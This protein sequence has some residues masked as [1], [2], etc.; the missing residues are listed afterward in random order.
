MEII[1]YVKERKALL[2]SEI[3]LRKANPVL[4][5]V[6]VNDDYASDKYI[7][8]KLNDALEVGIEARHIKLSVA[9]SEEE[10]LSL[11]DKLNVQKD[12]HGIIVQ[13]PLPRHISEEKVKARISVKKDVDGF[14]PLSTFKACTPLGIINYLKAEKVVFSGK[15]ALVIGRSNIVG[16][17]MA[18]LLLNE[19][20]TVTIVH[21]KTTKEDL[22]LYLSRADIIVVAV[23][24]AHFIDEQVL[25]ES[26]V[27]VDVGINRG[28]D[29]LLKGDARPALKV[30]LQTPVPGGVGLLTRLTLLENVWEAYKYGI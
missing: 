18:E 11:I 16:R 17:P 29:G 14:N 9:T 15:N 10:L 2:K 1:E 22:E 8:G 4:V 13:L 25:K 6:Q 27:V 3:A 21:S 23:G 20:A 7:K 12:V 5:I 30:K 28:S 26:A 24:K 19:D